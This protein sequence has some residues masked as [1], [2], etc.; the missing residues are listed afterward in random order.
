MS[1][2]SRPTILVATDFSKSSLVAMSLGFALSQRLRGRV[3]LLHV[4]SYVPRHRYSIP[5]DWMIREIRERTKRQLEVARLRITRASGHAETILLDD[6]EQPAT[7]IMKVA[8]KL[9]RPVIVLGTHSRTGIDRFFIGSTAEEV[10]RQAGCPVVTVGPHVT[11]FWNRKIQTVLLASDLTERSLGSIPFLTSLWSTGM[12]L[13]VLHVT[14]PDAAIAPSSW[15][16]NIRSRMVEALGQA[17]V[18]KGMVFKLVVHADTSKAIEQTASLE[19]ADLLAI[20][21]HPAKAFTAHVRATTGFQIV[22]SAPCP[23]VSVCE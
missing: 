11:P 20:G 7:G 15:S 21:V 1:D 14:S 4:F 10:L 23:V 17:E 12:R 13:V 19:K 9:E 8:G 6:Q 2:S 22:M 3:L 5:V 18:L 16:D